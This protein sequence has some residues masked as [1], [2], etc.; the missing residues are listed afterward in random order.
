MKNFELLKNSVF[1]LVWQT[2]IFVGTVKGT[3]LYLTSFVDDGLIVVKSCV[4]LEQL[5]HCLKNN[6]K[7]QEMS[8]ISRV[9]KSNEIIKMVQYFCRNDRI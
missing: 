1:K 9:Y 4:L 6:L 2:H 7:L 3:N 8:V 5:L